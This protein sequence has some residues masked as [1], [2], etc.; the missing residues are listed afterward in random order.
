M[1]T[2]TN[3]GPATANGVKL[4]D[5]LPA[6]VTFVASEASQGDVSETSGV[7]IANLGSLR[8][9]ESATVRITA[10]AARTGSLVNRV[11]VVGDRLDPID[12]NNQAESTLVVPEGAADRVGPV[13]T[14]QR[15]V[16]AKQSIRAIVLTFNED[17]NRSTASNLLN[18]VL[19]L[20]GPNPRKPKHHPARVVPLKSASYDVNSRTVTLTPDQPLQIGQFYQ[21]TVNGEARPGL[22]DVAGNLL[23]GDVN[24]L[25]DGILNTLVGRGTST[26]PVEQ[27]LPVPVVPQEPPPPAHHR[28]RHRPLPT[29][30]V[31]Q[32]TKHRIV[33][34]GG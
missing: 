32:T 9:G 26:R 1:A 27:Q 28:P 11:T 3:L 14:R 18:Y 13:V 29:L 6:G 30:V 12:K 19:T 34:S 24:G 22:T 25:P 17:M 2:V 23:D 10:L 33:R 4:T 31:E 16:V 15:L 21:L 8:R 5:V 20:L 7:V